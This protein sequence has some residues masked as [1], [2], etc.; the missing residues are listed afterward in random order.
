ML[1]QTALLKAIKYCGS[2]QKKL[3]NLIGE[4]PDKIS[5]WLNRAKQIPF[6]QAIAIEAATDGL[7]SR[8]DLAPY[9]RVKK[10]CGDEKDNQKLTIS[11]Q[12]YIG[13]Q[14]EKMLGNRRGARNDLKEDQ[15]Q[16]NF[17]R[18]KCAQV[19]GKTSTLAAKEAGFSSR[20]TYLRAKKVVEKGIADVVEAMDKKLIS[21]ASAATIV[22]LPPNEQECLIKKKRKEIIKYLK[23]NNAKRYSLVALFHEREL[24]IAEQYY[25]LPLRLPL[26]GLLIN[27]DAKGYFSW[28]PKKLQEE[29][30]PNMEMN[31]D[32]ILEI[33]RRMGAIKKICKKE[34]AI[35]QVLISISMVSSQTLGE[36]HDKDSHSKT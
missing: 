25:K 7:I 9:A 24:L 23:K 6:H 3:A 27:S 19:K 31:F 10:N 2:K 21:I 33:L 29:L 4:E 8:Y 17:H 20:D 12:V 30:L 35:G 28:N 26:M 18:S 13:M 5:Y 1:V 15:L 36:K 11:E 32:T 34:G 16:A 14:L 22:A